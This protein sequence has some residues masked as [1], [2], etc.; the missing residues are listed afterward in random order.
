M[1]KLVLFT[2]LV[3]ALLVA[4]VVLTNQAKDKDIALDSHPSTEGQPL[5][6]D[7]DAPV[8]VVEF[9]D[10][11]CPACK[12][13][14]ER[15]YPQLKEDFID[16]GKANLSYV[17]V[18]FHGQESTL[19]ALAAESVFKNDPDSYWA[20]QKALFDEQ[21]EQDHD[22]A[23][24]TVDKLVEVA[25]NTTGMDVDQLRKEIDGETFRKQLEEDNT[26]VEE[27]KIESTPTVIISGVK[28]DDPYDYERIRSLIE[29]G[30]D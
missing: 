25:G 14:G 13:W 9:G 26:L 24:I 29:E 15:I 17:N 20:F 27:F 28:L 7:E 12:A 5:L 6:G 22:A 4:I 18:L 10:F 19:A 23:W 21:P 3:A 16:T 8:S 1:K 11:K 30:Q 2:V